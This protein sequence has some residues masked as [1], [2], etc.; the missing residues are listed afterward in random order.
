MCVPVRNF[1]CGSQRRTQRCSCRIRE[2]LLSVLHGGASR[3]PAQPPA[4][5][6]RPPPR[7]PSRP[8]LRG[9]PRPP[10][11]RRG[12]PGASQPGCAIHLNSGGFLTAFGLVWAAGGVSPTHKPRV[13]MVDQAS[14]WS[15]KKNEG[16]RGRF[17]GRKPQN[18]SRFITK[19]F[20]PKHKE[21][22]SKRHQYHFSVTNFVKKSHVVGG[23]LGHL[24]GGRIMTENSLIYQ[25][26][27]C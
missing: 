1:G 15:R 2:A 27:T 5:R 9:P 21:C 6:R 17:T 22:L 25:P 3:Q 20:F 18:N 23:V 7:G 11:P 14:L 4:P 10:T 13:P 24:G 26:P 8:P 16:F 12:P 19:N